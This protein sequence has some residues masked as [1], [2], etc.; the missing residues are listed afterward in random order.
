MKQIIDR[1][2][3]IVHES[4]ITQSKTKNKKQAKVERELQRIKQEELFLLIEDTLDEP[5]PK[6]YDLAKKEQ[7]EIKVCGAF[8]GGQRWCINRHVTAL[9]KAGYKANIYIQGSLF[10]NYNQ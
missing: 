1:L 7:T 9:R 10:Y 4:C 8:Y 6:V 3:V 2:F 5:H